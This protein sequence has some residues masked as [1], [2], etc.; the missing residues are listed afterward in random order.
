M[1]INSVWWYFANFIAWTRYQWHNLG[2]QKPNNGYALIV[3]QSMHILGVVL[4]LP[5]CCASLGVHMEIIG[6]AWWVAENRASLWQIDQKSQLRF[7]KL[8]SFSILPKPTK[9]VTWMFQI[10]VPLL[11]R[12]MNISLYITPFR[13]RQ[14][15]TA[16][17][18]NHPAFLKAITRNKIKP[19][20]VSFSLQH[21]SVLILQGT[22]GAH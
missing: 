22:L 14:W 18:M 10:V 3:F 16:S 19:S 21:R 6:A 7:L 20:D 2:K 9:L 8:N 1:I 12:G 13:T 15:N 17:L 4:Y 5:C 11:V